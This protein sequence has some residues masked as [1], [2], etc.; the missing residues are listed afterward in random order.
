MLEIQSQSVEFV[1]FPVTAT[2]A[3]AA[4]DP[5]ADTVKVTFSETE[6]LAAD[7]TWHDG[8]WEAGVGCPWFARCLVG[9]SPGVVELTAGTWW[10]FVKITDSPEVPVIKAGPLEVA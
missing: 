4:Y 10:A 7:A 3:G 8:S 9:P 5:T 1:R 6:T 2:K